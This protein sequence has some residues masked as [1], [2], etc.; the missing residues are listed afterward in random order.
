MMKKVFFFWFVFMNFLP[1]ISASDD[2]LYVERIHIDGES[3][4]EIGLHDTWSFVRGGEGVRYDIN[5][6]G[7]RGDHYVFYGS[8]LSEKAGERVYDGYVLI[9]DTSGVIVLEEQLDLGF[10]EEVVRLFSIDGRFVAQCRQTDDATH[11]MVYTEHFL[12]YEDD[13]LLT[14]TSIEGRVLRAEQQGS[15]LFIST[16]RNGPFEFML[17]IDGKTHH[18]AVYGVDDSAVYLE[19]VT[20]YLLKTVYINGIRYQSGAHQINYPGHYILEGSDDE[21]TFTVEPVIHGI[22]DDRVTYEEVLIE[23]SSGHVFLNHQPMLSGKPVSKP[24]YYILTIQG[25]NGYEKTLDFTIEALIE[26]IDDNAFYSYAPTLI[27]SGD[28]Y[29]NN[30]R[31]ASGYQ[32]DENGEHTFKISGENGYE[33]EKTFTVFED[34]TDGLSKFVTLEIGLVVSALFIGGIALL[35]ILKKRQ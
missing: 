20:L 33:I 4:L 23:V 28:G 21:L 19:E 6:Y 27:F 13:T 31:I 7:R 26:G 17:D 5:G 18:E 15:M 34:E 24:G 35:G 10:H 8:I 9:V 1:M 16:E 2:G 3:R 11:A 14:T 12:I 25:V 30:Q 22:E 29:L 32:V